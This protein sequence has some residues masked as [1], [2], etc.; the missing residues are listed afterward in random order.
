MQDPDAC[1]VG[2]VVACLPSL[3]GF[4]LKCEHV[5]ARTVLYLSEAREISAPSQDIEQDRAKSN[6]TEALIVSASRGRGALPDLEGSSRAEAF[7]PV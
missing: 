2:G 7:D 1:L 5:R 4:G 6:R 3:Q